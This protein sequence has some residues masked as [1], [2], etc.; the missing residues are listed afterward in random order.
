MVKS[1][2]MRALQGR[3]RYPQCQWSFLMLMY[4][5][6]HYLGKLQ[7]EAEDDGNCE[8]RPDQSITHELMVHVASLPVMSRL[9]SQHDRAM[10]LPEGECS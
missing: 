4:Q 3:V 7:G 1:S 6:S 9:R 5:S 8:C 10:A 2:Y